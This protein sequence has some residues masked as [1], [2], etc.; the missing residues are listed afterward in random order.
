MFPKIINAVDKAEGIALCQVLQTEKQ[1]ELV[2]K[3]FKN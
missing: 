2:K 3:V 1:G